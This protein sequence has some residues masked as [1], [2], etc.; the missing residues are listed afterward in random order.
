ML[1]FAPD[2]TE[3]PAHFYDIIKSALASQERI[4]WQ[5]A[6]KGYLS[7]QPLVYSCNY[8]YAPSNYNGYAKRGFTN[9]IYSQRPL[10]FH[11]EE[12]F[13]SLFGG[14]QQ[15]SSCVQVTSSYVQ[16]SACRKTKG[17]A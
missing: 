17:S 7:K 3:C 4:R 13:K 5:H 2:F 15:R 6:V 9:A 16:A 11:E 12:W 8:G 10:K 1:S 14:G